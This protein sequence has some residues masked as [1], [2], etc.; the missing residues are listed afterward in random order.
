MLVL[1]LTGCV[2]MYKHTLSPFMG[3]HCRFQPTCSTYFQQALKK[4]GAFKG[5]WR[6]VCRICRCHPWNKGGYDPP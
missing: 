6:G 5:C 3:R 4:Y 2:H 1:A